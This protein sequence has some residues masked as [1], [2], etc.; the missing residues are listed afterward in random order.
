MFSRCSLSIALSLM[1][2]SLAAQEKTEPAWVDLLEQVNPQRHAVAGEWSKAND[3]LTVAASPGARLTLPWKPPAEYDFEIK[4]TRTTGSNSIALIFVAGGKQASYDVDGWGQHLAGIQNIDGRTIRDNPTRVPNQ[5]LENGT[6]YTMLVRV[7]K[8]EV[9]ALLDGKLLTCYRGNGENLALLD[10]WR[11]PDREAIGIGA[12]DSATTFHSIR[13]RPAKGSMPVAATPTPN[14]PDTPP[15]SRPSGSADNLASLSDEF[16]DPETLENWRRIFRDEQTNAD[17][18]QRI[19]VGRTRRGALTLVPHASTWYQDYRGVLVYKYVE[20]DFVVTTDVRA[21][22]RQGNGA[23]RS[24]YSLAGIMVRTP[25]DVT[26]QTWRPG[27]ENYI[28]LSLGSARNPGRFQFEVK[29]TIDS[30]SSLEIDAAGSGHAVI[31]AARIGE[32]FIL[33]KATNDGRWTVHRRYRRPDMPQRLQVGFTVYT[34]YA[35]VS[36]L[37]PQQ[38]NT[39]VFRGGNPDLVASFDYIRFRRPEVPDS[40]RGRAF[41]DNRAVSDV[42]LLGFLGE[43]TGRSGQR[44]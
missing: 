3:R 29:T 22:N 33:L 8:D 10:L 32:H 44:E 18:L 34:D 35:S 28:F 24:Q 14:R 30:R 26:P 2:V 27:G 17:Q 5:A 13:V 12:W 1:T 19:D 43:R 36:R 23:P 20:G 37:T 4:F 42:E 25:R 39:R 6:T 31:Q 7:R 38:Q 9:Q 11:L 21:S 15:P 16:D 40:L 41:S